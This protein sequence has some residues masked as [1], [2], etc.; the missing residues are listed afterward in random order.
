VFESRILPAARRSYP[1]WVSTCFR[2]ERGRMLEVAP[3]QY[4]WLRLLSTQKY[5]VIWAAPEH[6]KS[7]HCSQLIPLW[8]LSRNP[9]L[10]IVVVSAT[11]RQ[12]IKFGRF[13]KE[14]VERNKI[15]HRVFPNVRPAHP[16]SDGVFTITRP[17]V[18]KDPSYQA[19]GINGQILGARV[20]LLILDDILSPQNTATA[21]QRDKIWEFVNASYLTR[22]SEVGR[23]IAVGVKWHK[24]DVLHRLVRDLG[25]VAR[26][27]PVVDDS[28]TPLWPSHW[29]PERVAERQSKTTPQ[30]W[31]R[32]YLLTLPPEEDTRVFTDE[33]IALAR[34][35]GQA[36]NARIWTPLGEDMVIAG[37]DLAAPNGPTES[38]ICVLGI[39]DLRCFVLSVAS[40]HWTAGGLVG[41]LKALS[42]RFPRLVIGVEN[43][44]VQDMVASFLS[45][46]LPGTAVIPIH[47]GAS[48]YRVGGDLEIA[49]HQ[50]NAGRLF[51]ARDAS[52]LS[53]LIEALIATT[54][55]KHLP[56]LVSAML[57]AWRVATQL[58]PALLEADTATLDTQSFTGP[59]VVAIWGRSN[60]STVYVRD[61]I[62]YVTLYDPVTH[63]NPEAYV[64]YESQITDPSQYGN[65]LVTHN[66]EIALTDHQAATAYA[67]DLIRIRDPMF[68]DWI[69]RKRRLA[70][71]GRLTRFYVSLFWLAGN[72][73]KNRTAFTPAG[74]IE[75]RDESTDPFPTRLTWDLAR[76]IGLPAL[77]DFDEVAEVY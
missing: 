73:L 15:Y 44:A 8:V 6:G 53:H 26:T 33:S 9:N 49:A 18:S 55:E 16:W 65:K 20:D 63:T 77:S 19:I 39:S 3:F 64:A 2:D 68:T 67:Q 37:V 30:E 41:R 48:V 1:I 5:S 71:K 7:V 12:A 13:I 25:Y 56:D 22:L 23:V 4:E 58:R 61:D 10:R 11:E 62:V 66:Y 45:D 74:P 59:Y 24:D 70:N 47:T 72:L 57:I 31:A 76:Q 28:G 50:M 38:A 21:Y 40:G 32:Q 69:Q 36:Y 60:M 42:E 46:V 54:R 35:R 29:T 75:T 43:N 14:T 27:F 34:S 52:G 17:I 51:F